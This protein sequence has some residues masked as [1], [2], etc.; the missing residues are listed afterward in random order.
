VR[1][2]FCLRVATVLPA[3]LWA[4]CAGDSGVPWPA[5]YNAPAATGSLR[6][7]ARIVHVTDTHLVDTLSPARYAGIDPLAGSAWRPHE[8]CSTQIL[9]G[10]VRA[11]NRRH[12]SGDSIDFVVHT[13]D[14]C[15]N[16]QRN[17][18]N[19]L[20]AVMDGDS[21]DPLSGPDDRPVAGRPP[22][23]VDPYLPFEA[24][25]LYRQGVH[26]SAPSI[27]WYIVRGNHD[28]Y[29]LG[30]FPIFEGAAGERFAP[31][32]LDHRPGFLLPVRLDPESWLAYGNITPAAPGPPPALAFPRLV[33]PSRLRRYVT[34]ADY[35][36]ILHGSVSSPPGHGFDAS[37]A[38]ATW[39]TVS[40]VSGVRLI[41]LDTTA[42]V[43]IAPASVH[44]EGALTRTQLDF[45][46]AELVAAVARD[47]LVIVATHH[48]SASLS[49]L[50]GSEV[51]PEEL[52]AVL[53]ECPN[54]VVHLCG[55]THRHRVSNQGGYLEIETASTL[56]WPQE[57]RC[58]ELWQDE[59]TDEVIVAYEVFS[60]LD[61]PPD[62]PDADPL[63][64]LREVAYELA[65]QDAGAAARRK[66][67]RAVDDDRY[68]AADD[69]A[70]VI[71]LRRGAQPHARPS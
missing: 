59:A 23:S 64:G 49:P 53:R 2:G 1:A 65:R 67:H 21:V 42:A 57:A 36:S 9:D 18:L 28:V 24:E 13:G 37:P 17:E 70:G 69:R 41:G 66:D 40:P 25:G 26:G 19:W 33:V 3:C 60:H 35:V 38:S 58:I 8:A 27:P 11:I 48:P 56:D 7:V 46:S 62:P 55:H 30:V 10:I 51:S 63:R 14:A 68:G 45:L 47:E 50:W 6:R 29:A 4:G 31:L 5:E 52:R 71:R 61:G 44:S 22:A 16:A 20:I 43:N 15:D 12:G 34:T 39:Y 54:V 32:P